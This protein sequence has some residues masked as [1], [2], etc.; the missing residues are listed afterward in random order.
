MNLRTLIFI[1]CAAVSAGCSTPEPNMHRPAEALGASSGE[2]GSGVVGFSSSNTDAV[3]V[4][5]WKID[6]E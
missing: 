3:T 4:D 1:A 6:A 5:Y 2:S